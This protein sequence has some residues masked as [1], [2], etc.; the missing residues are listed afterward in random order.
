[1]HIKEAQESVAKFA[2][3]RGWDINTPTQRGAHLAREASRLAEHTLY[4]EG[5]T[6]KAPTSSFEKQFGDVLFSLLSMAN[7]LGVDLEEQLLVAMKEDEAKYPAEATRA[8]SL[9]AYALK[10]RPF[11]SRLPR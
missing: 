3:G 2:V 5:V 1:M 11:V 9:R 4:R 7:R 8:A 6:T 10:M